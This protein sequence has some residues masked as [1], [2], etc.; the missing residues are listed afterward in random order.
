[1]V[2]NS[3]SSNIDEVLSINASAKVLV[4][5]DFSI[6]HK[7]WLTYYSGTDKPD[8]LCYNICIS[9]D[10]IQIVHFPTWIPDCDSHSPAL[11]D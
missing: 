9:E 2:F 8:E 7:N 10:L 11:L 6:Y 1:M 5:G 4:F 3:V